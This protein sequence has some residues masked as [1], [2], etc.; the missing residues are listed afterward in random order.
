MGALR[1]RGAFSL[2]PP[3][4]FLGNSGQAHAQPLG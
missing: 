3:R 4:L 2:G 1:S